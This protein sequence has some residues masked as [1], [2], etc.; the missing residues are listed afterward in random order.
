MNIH[1]CIVSHQALANLIPL[2]Q[3]KPHGVAL[4]VSGPMEAAAKSFRNV[5]ESQG[6]ASEQILDC[7]IKL[8]NY[9][10]LFEQAYEIEEKVKEEFPDAILTY[11]ATGGTKLMALAFTQWFSSDHKVIYS[12]TSAH[13]IE[14]LSPRGKS[15][16][17]MASVLSLE[18]YLKAGGKTLRKRGDDCITWSERCGK[19]QAATY[20][21]AHHAAG[22]QDFVSVLNR[23]FSEYNDGKKVPD[24]LTFD[25][26]PRDKWLRALEL[27]QQGG[28]LDRGSSV[29]D[30]YPKGGDSAIYLSGGWFEE[31]VWLVAK[32]SGAYDV[33]FD[34][35]F[36]DDTRP[37]SDVRNQ[38]DVAVLH[39][40]RLL[41]LECKTGNTTRDGRDA[42]MVYKL[43]SLVKQAAG[44][45][46]ACA[47]ISFRPLD[48]V[49]ATGIVDVRARAQGAGVLT[50]ENHQ[51][52][53]LGDCIQ[54][55]ISAGEWK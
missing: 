19:R 52:P 20:F 53:E 36:T 18:L 37:K 32:A 9:D 51:L 5:L 55:W 41:L 28:V 40:N 15:A 30:W 25:R 12:D 43:D 49:A 14:H 23:H 34:L 21:M 46:G 24:I 50:C 22:L 6:W 31:Y 47:L 44:S 27:L 2:L 33:A 4:I 11:N 7:P 1:L 16:D 38:I 3:Y 17:R 54:R 35:D 39:E 29:L 10:S 45:L 48:H 8:G 26:T 42:D 13:L